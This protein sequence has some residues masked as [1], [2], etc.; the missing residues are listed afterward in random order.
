VSVI[1]VIGV[2]LKMRKEVK[3]DDTKLSDLQGQ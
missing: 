1:I 2:L 3:K